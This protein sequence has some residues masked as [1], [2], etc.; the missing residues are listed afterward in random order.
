[1]AVTQVLVYIGAIVVLLL[2]GVMLTR[3]PI[4]A[5]ADADGP[6]IQRSVAAVVGL[7]LF[8]MITFVLVD[9]WSD[10]RYE[11][12]GTTVGQ[13]GQTTGQISD[14]IFGAYLVPFEAISVL[15]LAA[16]IGSIVLA[17]RD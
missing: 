4:G 9:T 1:M 10:Q 11:L 7:A 5:E 13:S 14:S 16:L 2:F 3:A 8:A 6:V 15:L 17:R 12:V